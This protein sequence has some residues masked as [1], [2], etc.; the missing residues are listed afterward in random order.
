MYDCMYV[1]KTIKIDKIVRMRGRNLDSLILIFLTRDFFYSVRAL[2]NLMKS[3]YGNLYTSQLDVALTFQVEASILKRIK[4]VQ[5]YDS[6][7]K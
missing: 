7:L 1:C 6:I 4:K 5:V 2:A 3:G